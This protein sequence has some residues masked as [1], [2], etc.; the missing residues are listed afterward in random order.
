M[1]QAQFETFTDPDD[2]TTS[3]RA[4]QAGL[5]VTGRGDF[6]A[7]PTKISLHGILRISS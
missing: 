1:P 2:Y 6:T 5:M 7:K 4:T 3:I